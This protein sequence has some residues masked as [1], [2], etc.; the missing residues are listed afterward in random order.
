[1]YANNFSSLIIIIAI[2]VLG[3]LAQ[4]I[5][6]HSLKKYNK[7]ISST[8]LPGAE[9]ARQMLAYYGVNN[10]P[11]QQGAEGQDFYDPRSRSITLS[12][13]VYSGSTVT[14]TAVVCHE[15]GHAC[16][17]AEGYSPMKLR[18]ALVPVVNLCSA[19]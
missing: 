12:P 3:L 8:N 2:L 11:I 10:V 14:S 19:L 13:S 15:V 16:Q 9:A 7:Y 6:N 17:H 1:M 5:A 4:F 18:T